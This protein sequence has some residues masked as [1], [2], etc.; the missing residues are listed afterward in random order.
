MARACATGWRIYNRR[1]IVPPE[2][3]GSGCTEYRWPSTPPPS[4]ADSKRWNSS[5]VRV[6]RDVLGCFAS[7][8]FVLLFRRPTDRPSD[9]PSDHLAAHQVGSVPWVL[10]KNLPRRLVTPAVQH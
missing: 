2:P 4:P 5:A 7:I 8:I 6:D 9:R 3:V 1:R 10:T